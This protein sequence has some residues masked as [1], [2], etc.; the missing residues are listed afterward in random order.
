MSRF[1][2]V[3]LYNK[4]VNVDT[5]PTIV[6]PSRLFRMPESLQGHLLI[7]SPNLGDPNFVKSIVLIVQHGESGALG[8]VLNRATKT[9]V[10]RVWEQIQESPCAIEGALYLGGPV[11]GP[12]VALHT[13]SELADLEII[14][15]LYYTVQPANLEKL[16]SQAPE[17][18][19]FI[20][21]YAGWGPGQLEAEINEGAWVT[22]QATLEMVFA[23]DSRNWVKLS[24]TAA[25]EQLA[26]L[27]GVKHVPPDPT[28]N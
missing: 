13:Q 14:S 18:I 28:V 19:R 26:A 1:A 5:S 6:R 27:L 9:T 4:G 2:A 17:P 10:R 7:S 23:D 11:E 15:G 25:D 21:G 8:L 24:R 12:L 22:T 3:L 16:V 20:A